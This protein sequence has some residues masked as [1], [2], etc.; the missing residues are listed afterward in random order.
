MSA[1]KG[2]AARHNDS[3]TSLKILPQKPVPLDL[4]SPNLY[5]LNNMPWIKQP[6]KLSVIPLQG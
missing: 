2:F 3:M 1:S 5:F 6:R 4:K